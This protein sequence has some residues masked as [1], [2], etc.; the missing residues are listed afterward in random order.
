MSLQLGVQAARPGS[1]RGFYEWACVG[2]GGGAPGPPPRFPAAEPA[3]CRA[4]RCC[5]PAP[6]R[7]GPPPA[8]QLL[9]TARRGRLPARVLATPLA[10]DASGRRHAP[11]GPAGALASDAPFPVIGMVS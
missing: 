3:T 8:S 6:P 1:A 10:G 9:L 5:L 4:A 11:G 7:P 2:R